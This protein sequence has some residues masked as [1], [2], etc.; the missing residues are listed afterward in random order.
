ML[1]SL[2][3]FNFS[4]KNLKDIQFCS[5]VLSRRVV[6]IS[7]NL[8]FRSFLLVVVVWMMMEIFSIWEHRIKKQGESSSVDENAEVLSVVS[9]HTVF[10]ALFLLSVSKVTNRH[11]CIYR[12]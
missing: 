10:Q 2:S 5:F 7:L 3:R 11:R 8:V 12:T 4:I 9:P 6:A 1:F